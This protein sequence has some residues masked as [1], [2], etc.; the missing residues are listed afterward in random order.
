[1]KTGLIHNNEANKGK[2]K[3]ARMCLHLCVHA[4]GHMHVSYCLMPQCALTF[5]ELLL[6]H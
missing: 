2:C 3:Y 5:R 6:L 4:G 1:M